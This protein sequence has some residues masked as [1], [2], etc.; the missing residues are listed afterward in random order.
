MNMDTH[1]SNIVNIYVVWH[2]NTDIGPMI[3]ESLLSHFHSDAFSGLPGSSIEVYGR[4]IARSPSD[5]ELPIPIKIDESSVGSLTVI[6][7]VVD[8]YL[9]AALQNSGDILLNSIADLSADEA[10]HNQLILPV[11]VDNVEVTSNVLSTV[12][13]K[14]QYI[15][16]DSI[17]FRQ[18]WVEALEGDLRSPD[19]YVAHVENV[20]R[21]VSQAITQYL[22]SSSNGRNEDNRI[23]IFINHTKRGAQTE[24]KLYEKCIERIYQGTRLAFIFDMNSFQTG[25]DWK[26]TLHDGVIGEHSAILMIRTDEF[27][28]RL[29]TQREIRLAKE[30][31]IPIVALDG[32]IDGDQR[33]SFYFDNVPIVPLP[34]DAVLAKDMMRSPRKIGKRGEAAVQH[35]INRLVDECLK[36]QVLLKMAR[37]IDKDRP[38]EKIY[39]FVRVPEPVAILGHGL[40]LDDL[41][42]RSEPSKTVIRH[43]RENDGDSPV[44]TN[45]IGI[46]PDPP[47]TTEEREKLDYIGRLISNNHVNSLSSRFRTPRQIEIDSHANSDSEGRRLSGKT[48]G[49]T[50]SIP[51]LL[52]HLGIG[53][54]HVNAATMTFARYTFVEGGRILFGGRTPDDQ[55]ANNLTAPICREAEN[56]G[57][58]YRELGNDEHR[59]PISTHIVPWTV[60]TKDKLHHLYHFNNTHHPSS[61]F[62]IVSPDG[63]RIYGEGG[64]SIMDA[65][66]ELSR[67]ERDGQLPDSSECH[68][69]FRRVL[70]NRTDLRIALGGRGYDDDRPYESGPRPGV[71]EEIKLTLQSNT[72]LYLLGG[73]GGHTRLLIMRLFRRLVEEFSA[74]NLEAD[75]EKVNAGNDMHLVEE[76][77]SAIQSLWDEKQLQDEVQFERWSGLSRDRYIQMATSQ[78]PAEIMG[79][80]LEGFDNRM[81]QKSMD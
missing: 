64:Y 58:L 52:N 74:T 73:Y 68:T 32:L 4:I 3:Y 47:M 5:S 13:A 38:N 20:T 63:N 8:A 61:V 12:Y 27:S 30:Y 25:M 51:K 18:C 46:Y 15:V 80:I 53:P 70:A 77:L 71:L 81:K 75:D 17:E 9:D 45:F 55:D 31:D 41:D 24:S 21:D 48:V 7:P 79:I 6:I 56:Y 11:V 40:G 1:S 26:K 65:L 33:G 57:E 10:S 67:I 43:L 49:L 60:V 34:R 59:F 62:A 2:P 72:P 54:S 37:N 69:H 29:W 50:V 78:R 44:S 16:V 19:K 39:T 76:E 35:A 14:H 66:A 28:R 22:I 23:R 42:S 36:K